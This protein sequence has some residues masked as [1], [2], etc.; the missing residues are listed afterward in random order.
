MEKKLSNNRKHFVHLLVPP[1]PGDAFNIA[2]LPLEAIAFSLNHINRFAGSAGCLDVLTHSIRVYEIVRDR[3]GDRSQ[4]LQALLHDAAEVVIGD[5]P[6][7]V[8]HSCNQIEAI[9]AF[10][11]TRLME[12]Y[13]LP[14]LLDPLV[15]QADNE[16][17]VEEKTMIEAMRLYSKRKFPQRYRDPQKLWLELMEYNLTRA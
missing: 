8:K 13:N 16:A 15:K 11:F 3:G 7:H 2:R 17:L 10:H 12:E 4:R 5:I 6:S 14:T 1:V 9:E